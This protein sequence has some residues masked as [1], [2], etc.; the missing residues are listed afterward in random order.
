[1]AAKGYKLGEGVYKTVSSTMEP[2]GDGTVQYLDYNDGYT[3]LHMIKKIKNISQ[4]HTHTH[5]RINVQNKVYGLYQ[6]QFPDI[7][8]ILQLCKMLKLREDGERMH[9]TSL[10]ISWQ[11]PICL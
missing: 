7:D 10:H 5:T 4:T 1:M 8:T 3:K 9:R 11:L 2:Y 6:W